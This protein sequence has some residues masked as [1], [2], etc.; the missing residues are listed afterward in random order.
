MAWKFLARKNKNNEESKK[1]DLDGIDPVVYARRWKVLGVMCV[2]LLVAILANSS[3]NQ[4]LPLMSVELNIDSLTMTWIVEVYLLVFAALLFTTAA[5]GDRYGRKRIM[6]IG[7]A[8]FLLSSAYA[9]FVASSGVELI[10]A[11]AVMG[12]GGAMVMPTTLSIINTTFPRRERARAIAI[13]GAVAGIGISVGSIVSGFLIEHFSWESVFIFNVVIA[14]A[15]LIANR[16]YVHESRDEEQTP[17][18]WGGAVFSTVG[19]VGLVYAIIEMPSHGLALDTGIMLA[20]G[21]LGLAG[22]IWWQK[23]VAAPM[24][25]LNLFKNKAFTISSLTLTLVFFAQMAIFFSLSQL[26]QSL[27][28]YSPMVSSLLTLPLM[29]PMMLV[30][31]QVPRIVQAIG[32]RWTVVIGLSAISLAFF[33]IGFLWPTPP[34]YWM[35]LVTLA[36]LMVGSAMATTPGTN[37]MMSSVPRNRSGMGAALNDTTRELGGALGIAILGSMISSGYTKNVTEAAATFGEKTQGVIEGSIAMALEVA[38]HTGVA[39]EQLAVTVREAWMTGFSEASIVAGSIILVAAILAFSF[40]PK[41][42]DKD[43]DIL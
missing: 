3:L 40:L 34:Q 36:V 43:S 10:I 1:V 32:A 35:L 30:A 22:F 38:K 27:M 39:G 33:V 24:L 11:R 4:A 18:D 25:D 37:I 7:L 28:G 9:G 31:P 12:I 15:A 20:V 23:R 14:G 6:Q 26:M 16:I 2:V 41:E 13:W 19:L 5:L 21:V 8:I 17:I 29:I 42:H